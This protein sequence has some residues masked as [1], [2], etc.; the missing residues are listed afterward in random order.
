MAENE[1]KKIA[2]LTSG[3]DAPGMNA[4]IRA[5]VRTATYRGI[6]VVGVRKGF[7]GLIHGEI[8]DLSP[9]SV[10]DTIHRGGTILLTARCPE[11]MTKEGQD[12]AATLCNILGLDALIVI[13]GDGSLTGALELSKRGVNIIGI[14]ATIDLDL[15]CSDYTIGFDTAV[16]TGMDAINKI[17]DTSTSHERCSIVEVMGRNAGYLALWCSVAGGAEDVL[18]PEDKTGDIN[19]VINLILEN[20][21]KGKKHNLIIVAEGI[22]GSVAMA[23]EIERVTGITTRA[24]ILGYLQR[25]GAPT[26]T[27]RMHASV[28]G[29]NAIE[30]L[31]AGEKNRIIIYKD[32]KHSSVDLEEGLNT[33]KDYDP[34]MYNMVKI[35]SI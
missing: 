21:S 22:G 11:M 7:S 16:N 15:C 34:S 33:Q 24:T 23:K 10:S 5:V 1:I 29:Y 26:A 8:E 17:R 25:G 19:R 3:G 32:G 20:R 14:P 18:I 35:L 9:R 31:A 2:V 27:D 6:K 4:T 30:C 13:G 12:K 28:M